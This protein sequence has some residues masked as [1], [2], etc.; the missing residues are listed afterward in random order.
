[1]YVLDVKYCGLKVCSW[2]WLGLYPRLHWGSYQCSPRPLCCHERGHTSSRPQLWIYLLGPPPS[3]PFPLRY[4]IGL[5]YYSCST[6]YFQHAIL[7][8]LL[9]C[10]QMGC[11]GG[12]CLL[13]FCMVWLQLHLLFI[14]QESLP[15]DLDEEVSEMEGSD[16]EVCSNYSPP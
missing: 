16:K 12:R 5:C 13:N 8:A 14:A 1:M 11:E 6:G 9:E 3:L 2:K 10:V 4:Y 7:Q 15:D